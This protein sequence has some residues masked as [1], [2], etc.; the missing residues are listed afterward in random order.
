MG[1]DL[2]SYS[3]RREIRHRNYLYIIGEFLISYAIIEEIFGEFLHW[4]WISLI[5]H[6]LHSTHFFYL[7]FLF[8]CPKMNYLSF[9]LGIAII[10]VPDRYMNILPE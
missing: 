9:I 2:L 6:I 4:D 3:H 8:E 1:K 10:P 5:T 7:Y